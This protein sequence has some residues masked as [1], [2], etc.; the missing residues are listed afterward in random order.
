MNNKILSELDVFF[1]NHEKGYTKK[2]I[3]DFIKTT[4]DNAK[5][6]KTKKP[7][8]A[9]QIFVKEQKAILNS[10]SDK[11]SNKELMTYIRELWKEKKEPKEM[12]DM[13]EMKETKAANIIKNNI[14]IKL[15]KDKL[16]KLREE[17]EEKKEVKKRGRKPKK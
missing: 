15:A 14:K 5:E 16:K 10:Q 1:K 11:K 2:E 17:I 6:V 12:K 4:Y 7:L 8:N 9:Y 13:K 3:I